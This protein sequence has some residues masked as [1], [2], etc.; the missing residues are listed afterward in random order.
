MGSKMDQARISLQDV[1]KTYSM[2]YVTLRLITRQD[3]VVFNDTTPIAITGYDDSPFTTPEFSTSPVAG[4]VNCVQPGVVLSIAV[5]ILSMANNA[6]LV[7]E[8]YRD[9]A[10]SGWAST[11]VGTGP[12]TPGGSILI[13]LTDV[14]LTVDIVDNLAAA[15]AS[16]KAAPHRLAVVDLSLDPDN[17]S[18]RDGLDV[19]DA[20]QRLDPGCV[21]VLLTG[22]ATFELAVSALTEYN[23]FTCLRKGTFHRTEFRELVSQ[24]LASTPPTA[25]VSA[26]RR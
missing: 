9:G 25:T 6:V 17:H 21:T 11:A 15:I 1:V 2:G 7:P 18:N 13:G 20:V 26:A 8:M 19:L 5:I 12:N 23:V 4:T 10:A 3:G 14:G 24:A 16:L 22:Y